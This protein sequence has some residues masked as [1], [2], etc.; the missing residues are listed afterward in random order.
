MKRLTIENVNNLLGERSFNLMKT[1]IQTLN[2]AINEYK[3]YKMSY[4][5]KVL[6]QKQL[7]D[8]DGN[9][10]SEPLE[11][12]HQLSPIR[13]LRRDEIIPAIQQQMEQLRTM[14]ENF[15][16]RGSGWN[17]IKIVEVNL[18]IAKYQPIKGGS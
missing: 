18:F 8:V 11:T 5:V 3:M 10:L 13:I 7:V 9:P 1:P 15:E 14:I 17:F 12:N 4:N 16:G 2:K 6:Y